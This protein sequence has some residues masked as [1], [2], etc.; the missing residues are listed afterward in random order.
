[1]YK[2]LDLKYNDITVQI[3]N[4]TDNYSFVSEY[5]IVSSKKIRQFFNQFLNNKTC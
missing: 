5:L 1:M 4:N 2:D 3:D